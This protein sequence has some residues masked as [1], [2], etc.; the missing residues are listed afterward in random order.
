MLSEYSKT[1]V[2]MV[3]WVYSSNDCF[4]SKVKI[5]KQLADHFEFTRT[6]VYATE[7]NIKKN[8]DTQQRWQETLA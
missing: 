4:K 3:L 2:K 1:R 5:W 6:C 8:V 7:K